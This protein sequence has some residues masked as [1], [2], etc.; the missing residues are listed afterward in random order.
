M[1]P[2]VVQE[3][4]KIVDSNGAGIQVMTPIFMFAFCN[5]HQLEYLSPLRQALKRIL[6]NK[7]GKICAFE[8]CCNFELH[9]F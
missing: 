3:I 5:P 9:L 1:W 4:E 8:N 6:F 2:F 7:I